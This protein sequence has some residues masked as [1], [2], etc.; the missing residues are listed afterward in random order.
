MVRVASDSLRLC[1]RDDTGFKP[2]LDGWVQT[3]RGGCMFGQGEDSVSDKGE[4][5]RGRSGRDRSADV[6][7]IVHGKE[8]R[9]L[10]LEPP[11]LAVR[12]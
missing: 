6:P 1:P 5:P 8:A 2:L 7:A 9:A 12:T 10:R 11:S 4:Q 3:L